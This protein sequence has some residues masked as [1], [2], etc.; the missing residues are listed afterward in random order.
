[1]ERSLIP[2]PV[3]TNSN[4]ASATSHNFLRSAHTQVDLDFL[5]VTPEYILQE[6]S[7]LT[8]LLSFARL[9]DPLLYFK[10]LRALSRLCLLAHSNLLTVI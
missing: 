9:C 7:L 4:P 5:T 1:M 2:A 6:I 8:Y 3:H 10:L